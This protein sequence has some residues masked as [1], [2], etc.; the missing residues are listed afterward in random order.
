M[1]STRHSALALIALAGAPVCHA[2]G[3]DPAGIPVWRE[4]APPAG[5]TI[6]RVPLDEARRDDDRVGTTVFS[7][8]DIG[9]GYLAAP[10]ASATLGIEDYVTSLGDGVSDGT[11]NTGGAITPLVE[12][13]FVGGVSQP[14]GILFFQFFDTAATSIIGEFGVQFAEGGDFF[15]TIAI[16]DP[17]TTPVPVEGILVVFTDSL[18]FGRCFLSD[19]DA[20][21]GA[22]GP[23]AEDQIT[24]PRVFDYGDGRGPVPIN[25]NFRLNTTDPCPGDING[26][27]RTDTFDFADL[28]SAFGSMPGDPDWNPGADLD[29]NDFVNVFDFGI[30][31]DDFGCGTIVP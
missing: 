16:T 19:A 1:M 27:F 24:G 10:A 15:Y 4:A 26:D 28:T 6:T 5:V 7:H 21:A 2:G 3:F 18:S 9:A 11:D 25:Y 17:A 30:L 14:G 29:G 31:A 12:F 13:G 22:N 23:W 20:T 8:L